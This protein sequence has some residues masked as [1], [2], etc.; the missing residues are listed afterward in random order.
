MCQHL[1]D[2]TN[3]HET[4]C[5]SSLMYI[6]KWS[7]YERAPSLVEQSPLAPIHRSTG[8]AAQRT[9][10]PAD[11]SEHGYTTH[12]KTRLKKIGHI[13]AHW[14]M[15]TY[16]S[17]D[18][19]CME[20]LPTFGSFKK[21]TGERLVNIPFMEYMRLDSIASTDRAQDLR[22]IPNRPAELSCRIQLSKASSHPLSSP[23]ACLPQK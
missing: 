2:S 5:A 8:S 23:D 19:P 9:P 21:F 11:L 15:I 13:D 14:H 17:P 18:A 6:S 1:L 3:I 22:V 4:A 10:P 20:H 7:R 12:P 16:H